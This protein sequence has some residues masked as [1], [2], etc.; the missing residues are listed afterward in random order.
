MQVLLQFLARLL[1]FALVI[2]LWQL[3]HSAQLVS[4]ALLPSPIEVAR[5]GLRLF[6]TGQLGPHI[7]ASTLRVLLGVVIGVTIAIPVGFTL[8]W[9]P[10]VRQFLDPLIN[11]FRALPPIALVP[12]VVVYFGI[13]E[14]G[15]LFVLIYAA[16]FPATIVIYEGITAIESIYIRAA[17][18][19]G[20]TGPE[21]F[22]RVILPLTLPH[23]LTAFRIA[24][25]VAW[26]TLVAAEL[27]A[28][29]TG[30][31]ALIQDASNFF[32]IPTIF[33]GI[34]I[35]GAIALTMDTILRAVIARFVS[36]RETI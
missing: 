12:L 30:L 10:S 24:L 3:I 11:F 22:T 17:R 32:Q 7:A 8:G 20:A 6:G 14:N 34:I 2:L 33:L 25:G 28:A 5:T 36:W 31:G 1:P 35:I 23:I 29:R 26:A 13:G 15:R 27:V 16:F 18:V 4:P 21:L 9:Y 19:L